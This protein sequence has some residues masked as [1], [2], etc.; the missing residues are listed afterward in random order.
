MKVCKELE[1]W[2]RHFDYEIS[3]LQAKLGYFEPPEVRLLTSE[4]YGANF[5]ARIAIYLEK[6]K[7]KKAEPKMQ[8]EIKV[9]AAASVQANFGII[10]SQK[11]SIF[12]QLQNIVFLN[13][14]QFKNPPGKNDQR[15]RVFNHECVHSFL[16]QVAKEIAFPLGWDL[17][18]YYQ[19]ALGINTNRSDVL[20]LHLITEGITT[21]VSGFPK[22]DFNNLKLTAERLAADKHKGISLDVYNVGCW[23]V[24]N[25]DQK[26]RQEGMN[27]LGER[28]L[29]IA[30]NAPAT[31]ED[32][33]EKAVSFI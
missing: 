2:K 10:S 3:V 17:P 22:V 14:D 24:R 9:D 4:E 20:R 33:L 28:M 18:P 19:K 12:D 31:L 13:Q 5:E 26:L 8:K 21:Y 6:I 32:F 29:A 23:Y 11:V 7:G 15:T 1:P 16:Y 30:G 27:H 25:E